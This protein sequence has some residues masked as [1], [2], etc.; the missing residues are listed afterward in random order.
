GLLETPGLLAGKTD[1]DQIAAAVAVDVLG[2]I[3][4]RNA[5]IMRVEFL[6][7]LQHRRHLPIGGGVINAAGAY[8][9][10]AISVEIAHARA[11]AAEFR[12]ELRSLE[13]DVRRLVFSETCAVDQKRQHCRQG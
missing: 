7:F 3:A 8:V 5:V 6:G 13:R 9:E 12:V 10:L 2:K 1:D 11:F 4:K